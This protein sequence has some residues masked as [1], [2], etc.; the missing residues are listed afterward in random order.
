MRAHKL[1]RCLKLTDFSSDFHIC[2][3]HYTNSDGDLD[4]DE[5]SGGGIPIV[6][7][8]QSDFQWLNVF[9]WLDALSSFYVWVYSTELSPVS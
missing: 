1:H 3:C 4:Y 7:Q 6:P 9:H 8:K 5:D 2:L